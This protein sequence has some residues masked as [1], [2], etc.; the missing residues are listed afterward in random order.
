MKKLVAMIMVIIIAVFTLTG[1][2][3][4]VEKISH[5]GYDEYGNEITITHV[6]ELDSEGNLVKGYVII[7]NGWAYSPI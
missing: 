1:C 5:L 4:K 2:G 6:K 3:G 7:E